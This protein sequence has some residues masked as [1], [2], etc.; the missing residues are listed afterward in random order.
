MADAPRE[1]P[2]PESLCHRCAALRVVQGARSS[3]LMCTALEEK[4]PRQPVV[5]CLA[6]KQRGAQVI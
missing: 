6:F 2:Y 3:F 1:L 5:R 4:Y